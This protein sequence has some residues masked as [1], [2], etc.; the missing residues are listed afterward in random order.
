M[1]KK[2]WDVTPVL[3]SVIEASNA[4]A[5][6]GDVAA[7]SALLS[8]GLMKAE[9][10]E[11]PIGGETADIEKGYKEVYFG[12]YSLPFREDRLRSLT[13][14]RVEFLNCP[15]RWQAARKLRQSSG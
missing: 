9:V 2:S 4:A 11:V 13:V 10:L 5:H 15:Q 8:L 6:R 3:E 12:L 14:K 1:A 7:D